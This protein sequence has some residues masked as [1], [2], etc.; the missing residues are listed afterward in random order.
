MKNA[1]ETTTTS[2]TT[3]RKKNLFMNSPNTS[4]H[5]QMTDYK[6]KSYCRT[7]K[8]AYL[9]RKRQKEIKQQKKISF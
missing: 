7:W 8:D 9:Q 3:K 6:Q 2:T 4:S 5:I 1:N